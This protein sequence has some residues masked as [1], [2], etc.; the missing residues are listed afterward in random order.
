MCSPRPWTTTI[1]PR[2]WPAGAH[3]R[4]RNAR[5]SYVSSTLSCI[6]TSSD[7]MNDHPSEFFELVH[8]DSGVAHLKLNRPERMNTM[9]LGFFP[10]ARARD[11]VDRQALLRWHG[12]RR[13]RRRPGRPRRADGARAPGLPG[14]AQ[15]PHGLLHR[16]RR[17]ALSGR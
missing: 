2:A 5:P 1:V 3:S 15:A 16:T 4:P 17:S 6:S 10:D 12:A 7:A 11:L 13:L 8:D 9:T 14:D